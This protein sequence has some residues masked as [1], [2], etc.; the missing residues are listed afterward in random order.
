LRFLALE[1]DLP[2][3]TAHEFQPHLRAEAL[4]AWN[5]YCSGIIREASFREDLHTAVL[6]LECA[7]LSEAE[8]MVSSLPLVQA[9]LI[10]FEIFPLVPYDGFSRLFST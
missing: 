5:L 1:H 7:S 9:G 4:A 2:G 6:L 10:T 8:E 3:H